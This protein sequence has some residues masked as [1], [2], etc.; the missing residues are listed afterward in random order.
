MNGIRRKIAGKTHEEIKNMP[1]DEL[2]MDPVA[3]SDFVGALV[4][5][6]KSVSPAYIEKHEKWMSEVRL[7]D[8][9]HL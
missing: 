2:T 5:V 7:R 6:K 1:K 4:K 3:I 9:R 8:H